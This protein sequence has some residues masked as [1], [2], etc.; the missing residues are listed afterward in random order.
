MIRSFLILG[1]R[2]FGFALL[3]LAVQPVF[4]G[5]MA[6]ADF[7]ACPRKYIPNTSAKEGPFATESM[8]KARVDRVKRESP[9]ACARYSCKEEGGSA[10]SAPAAAGHE[11]DKN[12][13]DAMAAGLSGKISAG[14][15]AGLV[16]L[17]LLGNIILAP[18]GGNPAQAQARALEQKRLA[19]EEAKRQEA[20]KERL[21]GE[22]QGVENTANLQ[23]MDD[24]GSGEL[25]LMTGDEAVSTSVAP[26]KNSQSKG[27]NAKSKSAAYTKGFNDASGC[28]SQNAGPYC[29]GASAKQQQACLADYRTGFAS[30]DKQQKLALDEAYKAG[31]HAGASG[32][33]VN[34]ASD[35]RAQGSCRLPWIEAYNRGHF[36]GKHANAPAV[37][38]RGE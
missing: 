16:G 30:G 21:L 22:M 36:R 2:V 26:P 1:L 17:G 13:A 20:T 8:C 29:I 23:I 6:T 34:G 5:W 24:S 32:E 11:L 33:L 19:E 25:A 14:D 3:L 38:V 12:I 18:S 37:R 27:S 10:S 9:L 28:Y 4:A 7:T 35:P 15:A 31:Q